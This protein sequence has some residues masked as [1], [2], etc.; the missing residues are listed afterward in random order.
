MSDLLGLF[1]PRALFQKR[2]PPRFSRAEPDPDDLARIEELRVQG[3]Q[4]K[5]P[6][7]VRA[8]VSFAA[9]PPAREAMERMTKDGYQ[10]SVRAGQGGSWTVTAI[11]SLVPA[12]GQITWLREEM[13]KL[14]QELQGTYIGWDAPIVA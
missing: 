11:T 7:P 9:E 6:H 3:S 4:L 10:C 8:Y 2:K 14:G 1:V 12:P 13:V 5:V